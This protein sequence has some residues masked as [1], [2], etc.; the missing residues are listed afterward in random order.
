MSFTSER[1]AYS[2]FQVADFKCCC[3]PCR[4]EKSSSA[5][6]GTP[7][8]SK[9]MWGKLQVYHRFSRKTFCVLTIFMENMMSTMSFTSERHV[10]PDFQV[11]DFKCCCIP[12]RNRKSSS[13]KTGTPACSKE[14][15]QTLQVPMFCVTKTFKARVYTAGLAQKHRIK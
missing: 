11:E 1:H 15:S 3:I 8:C 5:K 14:T 9:G 12:C 10:Y 4:N 13:A 6:T 2:D 7:A